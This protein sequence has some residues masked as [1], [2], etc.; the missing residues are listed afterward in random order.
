[1]QNKLQ[2]T[3]VTKTINAPIKYVFDWCTDYSEADPQLTGSKRQR[4]I[5][6]KNNKRAVYISLSNE[7]GQTHVSVYVVKLRPSRSWHLDMYN[8]SR[9]ETAEYTLKA[10]SK[11]KTQLKIVFKNSWKKS[12]DAESDQEQSTRL[13]KIWDMYV[14]ALERDYSK[15]SN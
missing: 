10:L 15:D 3:R 14:A 9:N 4:I 6:D 1:L 11:D 2:L 13:N 7:D 8:P 12:D 5:I